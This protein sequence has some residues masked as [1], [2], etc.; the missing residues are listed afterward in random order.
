[1]LGMGNCVEYQGGRNRQGYGWGRF[2]GFKQPQLAHRAVWIQKYG[3][4]AEG[5][6]VDHICFNRACVNVEHLRLMTRSQNS[7]RRQGGYVK[8]THCPS[9]H[10]YSDDNS[11]W[12]TDSRGYRYPQCKTCHR[13]R[14]A[15][16]R[17]AASF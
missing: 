17:R 15:E 8:K 13:E 6:T 11:M 7:G 1:M 3:P 10:P 5:L 4:I 16:Y 9:G 12:S 14:Q 2:P